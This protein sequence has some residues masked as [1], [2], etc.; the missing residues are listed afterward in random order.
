MSDNS[1]NSDEKLRNLYGK[2]FQIVCIQL[3]PIDSFFAHFSTYLWHNACL[4][5]S[6]FVGSI[7]SRF[8][9]RSFA[10]A[11]VSDSNSSKLGLE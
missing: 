7:A 8:L 4:A 1:S 9:T 10:S 3:S 2:L 11:G 5:V 6:L